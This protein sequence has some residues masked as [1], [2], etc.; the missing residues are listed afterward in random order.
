MV[1]LIERI[2][3]QALIRL[4]SQLAPVGNAPTNVIHRLALSDNIEISRPVLQQSPVLADNFLVELAQ[5]KSQDHLAAIAE[6]PHVAE[7]VTDVLVERGNAAVTLKIAGNGGARFSRK[8]L[9]QVASRANADS[10]LAEIVVNRPDIPH[11]VFEHLLSKA[12]EVV[13]QRLMKNAVQS[14]GRPAGREPQRALRDIP[15]QPWLTRTCHALRP[16]LV[17]SRAQAH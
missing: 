16:S 2:E 14:P 17:I 3:Q 6:R 5:S 9:F 10:N 11:D 15:R 4:S 1:R 12:T 7:K 13:R 8:A